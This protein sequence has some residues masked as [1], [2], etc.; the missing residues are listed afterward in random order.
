MNRN[1]RT[2]KRHV[3]RERLNSIVQRSGA[4]LRIDQKAG[5]NSLKRSDLITA[6][7]IEILPSQVRLSYVH[8]LAVLSVVLVFN[9]Q[10]INIYVHLPYRQHRSKTSRLSVSPN[11]NGF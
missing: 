7:S 10:S 9:A 5:W 1:Y 4:V 6:R 3:G 8:A 11:R 2:G